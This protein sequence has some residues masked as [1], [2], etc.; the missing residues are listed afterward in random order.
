MHVHERALLAKGC[1]DLRA[2]SLTLNTVQRHTPDLAVNPCD[3]Q[4]L[5]CG[6]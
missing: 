2:I 1:Q 4:Q 6:A 3:S 5:S